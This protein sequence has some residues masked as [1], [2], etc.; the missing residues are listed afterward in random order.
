MG[1]KTSK[2]HG[3]L[4][5][6]QCI[7]DFGVPMLCDAGQVESHHKASKKAA[8][9]TQ[10]NKDRFNE[11]TAKRLKEMDLL[12]LAEEEITGRPLW[13]YWAGQTHHDQGQLGHDDGD[14]LLQDEADQTLGGE[15]LSCVLVYNSKELNK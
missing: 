6:A 4:H 9:L 8:N 3:I 5:V 7:Q 1:L 11:Q 15:S 13:H 12:A 14:P 2:V 10:K